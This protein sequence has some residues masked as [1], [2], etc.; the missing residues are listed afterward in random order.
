MFACC[1]C[2]LTA[3]RADD[4]STWSVCS[5]VDVDSVVKYLYFP[6]FLPGFLFLYLNMLRSRRRR[7]KASAQAQATTDSVK[8]RGEDK[9]NE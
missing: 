6:L 8:G 5:I 7:N 2:F 4:I 9:K 3:T 1:F